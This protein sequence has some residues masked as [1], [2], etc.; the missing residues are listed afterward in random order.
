VIG[1]L[2]VVLLLV[3][4]AGPLDATAKKDAKSP[5][6]GLVSVLGNGNGK[7]KGHS[8]KG[9]GSG[10]LPP[11]VP[12][13]V[14]VPKPPVS[15]K[16]N[17][18]KASTPKPATPSTP[19]R[20]SPR[21]TQAPAAGPGRVVTRRR[22]ATH[23]ASPTPR[24]APA[25]ASAATGRARR[26]AAARSRRQSAARRVPR[27][28]KRAKAPAK[29]R[30][31]GSPVSK[32]VR[33]IVEVVPQSVKI[34]L[35]GLGGLTI[36]LAAG[37]LLAALRARRLDRQRAVLL[38]DVGLLQRALL[39]PVPSAVGAVFTSVAYRPADGPGAGGDFYDTVPLPEGR[40]AFVLGDVSG[41]GRDALQ[42]TAFVRYTVR[43][44][45]EAGLE[46]RTALQLAGRVVD[47]KM[48][49]DFATVIAA[50]HDPATGTL[51]YASAGH[52]P[53][54]V[55]G[56]CEHEPVTSAAAPPLGVGE[57]TGLRQSVV[58]LPPGSTACLFTDGL[59]EARTEDGLLGRE[60]L[61]E[62]L[63]E[64]GLSAT[65]PELLDRVAEEAVSVPDDMAAC[66]LSP[67]AGVTTG[68]FR[69]EQLEVPAVD[70]HG[71]LPARFLADCGV[72]EE[73]AERALDE[74]RAQARRHRGAVLQVVLGNRRTVEVL[75]SNVESIES[76]LLRVAAA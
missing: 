65:A 51:T 5:A 37:S 40:S 73:D 56:P 49:G 76:A 32:T 17:V 72:P 29:K 43:A 38:Q 42:R 9:T 35:A 4:A 48:G 54:L 28:A 74:A 22:A 46:P 8:K 20:T 24:G 7:A 31:Q 55:I 1:A 47:G 59:I 19:T 61:G 62:L 26:R 45:L 75:P 57:R 27:H 70:L 11:V 71:P 67:T 50:V 36:L 13:G 14:P 2:T 53:P 34:A 68:R 18:P 33:D 25:R 41:H 52:P 60:R 66:V 39:P 63:R 10:V 15:P 30:S 23:R 58:P 6:P 64:L 21:P 16:V 3:V 44:Y 12:P 69:T